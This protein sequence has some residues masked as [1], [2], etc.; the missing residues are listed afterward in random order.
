[1]EKMKD[2]IVEPPQPPTWFLEFQKWIVNKFE[3][4]D[5]H[6]DRQEQFN[7]NVISRLDKIETDIKKIDNRLDRIIKFNNLKEWI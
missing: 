5:A 4:I 2:T 1:M 6:F 3:Q 7:S